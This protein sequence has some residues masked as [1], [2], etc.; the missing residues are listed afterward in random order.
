MRPWDRILDIGFVYWAFEHL[1]L[2]FDAGHLERKRLSAG[3]AIRRVFGDEGRDP[4]E[5]ARNLWLCL[6]RSPP[7]GTGRLDL[8]EAREL[9]DELLVN[10]RVGRDALSLSLPIE[11]VLA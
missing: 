6:P 4:L 11:T 8:R 2:K 9:R 10:R 3:N 1:G 7:R 5:T